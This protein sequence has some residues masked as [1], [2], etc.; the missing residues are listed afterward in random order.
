MN[1]L[2]TFK[3][4]A[5]LFLIGA[6]TPAAFAYS[7]EPVRDESD[8]NPATLQESS[9]EKEEE[10]KEDADKSPRQE[11][12]ERRALRRQARKPSYTAVT[13]DQ[14]VDQ[15]N[16]FRARSARPPVVVN[17]ELQTAAQSFAEH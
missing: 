14:I 1:G 17:P 16:N 8:A 10:D 6:L 2:M 12:T 9:K 4:A 11:R 15:I 13:R 7:D 5:R 3:N